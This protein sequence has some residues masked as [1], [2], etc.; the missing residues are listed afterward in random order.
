[1]FLNDIYFLAQNVTVDILKIIKV[2]HIGA[3]LLDF[4]MG[5]QILFEHKLQLWRESINCPLPAPQ[6]EN[7]HTGLERHHC[8]SPVSSRSSIIS[9]PRSSPYPTPQSLSPRPDSPYHQDNKEIH[10]SDILNA[11]PKASKLCDYY[12]QKKS[13]GQKER[14]LLID[15]IARYFEE[16]ELHL[17]L[18]HSYKL[19][20]EVLERFPSEKLV[21]GLNLL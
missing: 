14:N 4:D 3:L 18:A 1:M 9:S 5:T 19:E 16:R 11:M 6:C 21:G 17:S 2:H 20:K 12:D 10:L 7:D 15:V 13:F 8:I